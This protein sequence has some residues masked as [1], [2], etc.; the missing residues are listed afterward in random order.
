V[1]EDWESG[2]GLGF[3]IERFKGK[4][5]AGHGGG[6]PGNTTMTM[7]QIDDKVGVIVLTN[8]TDS[9]PYDIANQLMATVSDAVAKAAKAKTTPR[10]DP[11][12]VRFAGRYRSNYSDG[13]TQVVLLNQQLVLISGN[14][15]ST[16]V[17]EKLEPIG[18]G[19]FRLMAPDGGGPV[20]EIVWFEEKDGKVTRIYTG[21]GWSTRVDAF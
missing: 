7:A 3:D 21:D 15:R 20:G 19:R 11:A 14:A 18:D 10:W 6:Y 4:T 16:D 12:W 13:I 17:R 9:N 2:S 5:Y 1:D 8:T